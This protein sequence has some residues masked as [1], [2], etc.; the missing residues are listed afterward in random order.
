MKE[1]SKKTITILI[2]ICLSAIAYTQTVVPVDVTKAKIIIESAHSK[3]YVLIDGR[4]KTMY[5]EGHIQGAIV[6]D[7]YS[8]N[9]PEQLTDYLKADTIVV[10]CTVNN[11]SRIITNLL[12]EAQFDGVIITVTNGITAWKEHGFPIIKNEESEKSQ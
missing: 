1:I 11:R 3:G 7:A 4:S 8:D 5:N 6:I 10:Y 2:G 9:V 12:K